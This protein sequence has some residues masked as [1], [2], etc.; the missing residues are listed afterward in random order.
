MRINLFTPDYRV[1]DSLYNETSRR[2]F[3][4]GL[5]KYAVLFGVIGAYLATDNSYLKNDLNMRPDFNAMRILTP[6]PI[7][8]KKVFEMMHGSYFG[9]P[10]K[11]QNSSLWKRF[12][13]YFYP[14]NDYNPDKAY[15]EPFYDFKQDYV[16]DEHKNHYHFDL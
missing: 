4:Y 7:K 11:E 14:F 8:E 9:Q 6:V 12:I 15:Y 13:N 16:A 10:F 3:T 5:L 1:P 2:K